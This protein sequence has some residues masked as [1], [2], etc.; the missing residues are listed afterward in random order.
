MEENFQVEA[1]IVR[2]AI[3]LNMCCDLLAVGVFFCFYFHCFA[4]NEHLVRAL[5][6]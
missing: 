6:P 2:F 5:G 4:V 3:Q 1:F